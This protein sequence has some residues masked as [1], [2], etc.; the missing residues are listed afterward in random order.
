MELLLHVAPAVAVVT[1]ATALILMRRWGPGARKNAAGIMM[2]HAGEVRALRFLDRAI[3]NGCDPSLTITAML[4]RS[5][6]H[7]PQGMIDELAR[8]W[9]NWK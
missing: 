4:M 2:M 7:L 5:E 8:E 3:R 6:R 1:S 9:D